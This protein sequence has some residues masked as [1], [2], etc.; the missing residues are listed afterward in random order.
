MFRK[1]L[2]TVVATAAALTFASACGEG[3]S[4]GPVGPAAGKGGSSG[5][6]LLASKT[7]VLTWV[8]EN[9]EPRLHM[10][11]TITITNSGAVATS[12]LTI[13]DVVQWRDGT[14]NDWAQ[15]T[16]FPVATGPLAAGE[17][18][19]YPYDVVITSRD[20]ATYRNTANITITNHSGNL[21]TPFGP[22]PKSSVSWF[23]AP[24]DLCGQVGGCTLTR[25]YWGTHSY[26][27]PAPTDAAWLAFNG[28]GTN[29]FFNVLKPDLTPMDWATAFKQP[30]N[31]YY[32]QVGAQ[33]MAAWLN[34][35]VGTAIGDAAVVAA[36]ADAV[37]LL[38]GNTTL[39]SST[40]ATSGATA[41]QI[42]ATLTTFNEGGPDK[43][44][45]CGT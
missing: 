44:N 27:G 16:T 2:T 23:A 5:T 15:E 22:S 24:T 28:A 33:Y 31:N 38:S 42:V 4:S 10:V 37:Q 25:G 19:N 32:F 34:I 12:G 13:T 29:A 21:G 3:T 9:G 43:S 30:A 36:M 45:H 17:T 14:M 39:T 20:D 8:C 35:N 26:L 18:R 6:S 11:G 7:A 1:T 40:Q 41:A